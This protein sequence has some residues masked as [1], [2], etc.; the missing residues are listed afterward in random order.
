MTDRAR[1]FRERAFR[2]ADRYR[3]DRRVLGAPGG[4]DRDEISGVLDEPIAKDRM[5]EIGPARHALRLG[6]FGESRLR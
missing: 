6:R 1:G 5:P 4:I 3:H 2:N